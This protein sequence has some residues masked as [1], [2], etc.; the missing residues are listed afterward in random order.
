MQVIMGSGRGMYFK[1]FLAGGNKATKLRKEGK[2][3]EAVSI[4]TQAEPSEFVLNELRMIASEKARIA[5]KKGDWLEVVNWLEGYNA[6]ASRWKEYC[7]KMVNASPPKHTTTDK[8][9]L[10][11]A[12]EKLAIENIA[13]PKFDYETVK[14]IK[15]F[16]TRSNYLY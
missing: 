4:L 13:L 6:Y 7:R 14:V 15:R 16:P 2:L 12:K 10:I 11:L 1:Y 9:L 3:D 8:K 5:K